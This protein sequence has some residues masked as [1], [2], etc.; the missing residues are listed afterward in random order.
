MAIAPLRWL[1]QSRRDRLVAL[2][3]C[4]L[5][6]WER[7]WAAGAIE[8]CVEELQTP[9]EIGRGSWYCVGGDAGSLCVFTPAAGF[10]QLGCRLAA[11]AMSDGHGLAAGVGRR[12]F[13]DLARRL[14]AAPKAD[15]EELSAPPRQA[16]LDARNGVGRLQ[17]ELAGVCFRFYFEARL[18]DHLVPPQRTGGMPALVD[19]RSALLPNEVS[20]DA[21]LDLGRVP[22]ERMLMLQPGDIVKTNAKLDAP[23]ALRGRTA[24]FAVGTLTTKDGRRALHVRTLHRQ[25]EGK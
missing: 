25:G 3:Q 12:A 9:E 21:V 2:V 13:V 7:A 4:R 5:Q 18:C 19:R 23:I 11:L 16:L 8:C 14:G 22:V 20:L 1:S 6:E 17:V 15:V 24:S 10:E